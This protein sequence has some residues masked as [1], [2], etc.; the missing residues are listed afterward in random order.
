[1]THSLPPPP[2]N[3]VAVSP[4]PNA[5]SKHWVFAVRPQVHHL[6]PYYFSGLCDY[7]EWSVDSV[8]GITTGYIQFPRE[9]TPPQTRFPT[10]WKPSSIHYMGF[11]HKP[12]H[13]KFGSPEY[14]PLDDFE[15]D[16]LVNYFSQTQLKE[17]L[18]VNTPPVYYS[19]CLE[20]KN[21]NKF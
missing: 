17:E 12:P 19:S 21:K 9:V 14:P 5:P 16:I 1:M 6:M 3:F 8:T 10:V 20:Q 11:T 18:S 2:R 7:C 13:H 4:G 15:I